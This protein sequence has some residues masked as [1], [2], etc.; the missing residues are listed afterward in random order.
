MSRSVETISGAKVI[1]F[2]AENMGEDYDWR[3]LIINVQCELISKYPS[4][5]KI[6]VKHPRFVEYPYRENQIILENTY[7]QISLS[8]Y[9]GCGAFSVFVPE[10][11]GMADHWLAQTFEGIHKIISEFIDEL[12]H[13]GTFSNGEAVYERTKK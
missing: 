12:R 11:T 4:F 5:N 2:D 9:C 1:Y 3:D 13:I 7:V 6:E 8:E 10:H